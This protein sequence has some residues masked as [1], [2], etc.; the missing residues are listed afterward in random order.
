MEGNHRKIVFYDGI[1][2]LCDGAVRFVLPRDPNGHVRFASLQGEFAKQALAQ[3]GIQDSEAL[4]SIVLIENGKSYLRST[5]VL[6][7]MGAL[8]F[9][10]N[11]ALVFLVIPR[12]IRDF[13]YRWVARHR[14]AVFGKQDVCLLPRPEWRT[15]F[16]EWPG[17]SPRSGVDERPSSR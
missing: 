9:P 3:R 8:R 4:E 16:L 6:R 12:P 5:A 2:N 10:W 15:R 14:Y 17:E 11:L 1:C 7:I 13:V